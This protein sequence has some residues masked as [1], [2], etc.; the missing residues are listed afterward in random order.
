MAGEIPDPV[1]VSAEVPA[2]LAAP[3]PVAPVLEP[4]VVAPEAPAAPVEAVKP[5]EAPTAPVEP[6]KPEDSPPESLLAVKPAEKPVE[7][8]AEKPAEAA[9]PADEAAKPAEAPVEA[10]PEKIEWKIAFPET[11]KADEPTL[12]RFTGALDGLMKPETRAEAAQSLINQHNDA[13][14]AYDAQLRREQRLIFNN[15]R[16]EWQKQVMADPEIGGAGHETAMQSIAY[17]RDALI[18]SAK[19]GTPQHIQ[20]VKAFNDF[21]EVTGA[22]DHPIFDKMLYRARRYVMEPSAPAPGAKPTKT[23]GVNPNR[24]ASLYSRGPSTPSR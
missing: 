22:G 1:V 2:A 9:K 10:A 14:V 17:V 15:T 3:E 8:P 4:A 21:L 23:N 20:D 5:V 24:A 19:P 6:A 18:S 11:L 12:A 16:R 13:M 7:K